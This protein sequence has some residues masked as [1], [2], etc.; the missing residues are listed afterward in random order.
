[1]IMKLFS[2]FQTLQVFCHIST[3]Y[4]QCNI[5]KDCEIKEQF[6]PVSVEAEKIISILE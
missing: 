6:Y 5:K 3:A 2:V 1:M 4:S